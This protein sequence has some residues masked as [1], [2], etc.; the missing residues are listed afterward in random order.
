MKIRWLEGL[1]VG[2]WV[3]CFAGLSWSSQEEAQKKPSVFFPESA[4]TFDAVFES[5]VV[6]H[7]FVVQNKGTAALEV[8]RVEG[9]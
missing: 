1:C 7:D 2:V 3:L 8:K 6:P 5:V 9:G 4:H